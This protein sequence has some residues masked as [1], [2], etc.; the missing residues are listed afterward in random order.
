MRADEKEGERQADDELADFLDHLSER[1]GDHVPPALTV[2]AVGGRK[3]HD[4]DCGR[5]CENA[6]RGVRIAHHHG[7]LPV[8]EEHQQREEPADGR[9]RPGGGA[10]DALHLGGPVERI[11]LRDHARE[12][13]REPG[14]RQREEKAVD[15]VRHHK[16]GEA[17]VAEQLHAAEREFIEER[18]DLDDDRRSDHDR[19]A[20]EI[21]LLF[22]FRQGSP[23]LC[24]DAP[25]A[26]TIRICGKFVFYTNAREKASMASLFPR[27]AVREAQ[28]SRDRAASCPRRR[29][30][31]R[32]PRRCAG[33]SCPRRR[34]RC[35]DSGRRSC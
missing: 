2:A 24:G 35:A 15:V 22:G 1:R 34:R 8:E 23:S 20:V 17:L 14:G 6:R 25:H 21:I 16:V 32:R 10:E 3:A 18:R 12:R 30:C 31:S 28:V 7:K 5:K 19:R 27:K 11:R 13:H 29:E 4:H 26:S 33:W 9:E